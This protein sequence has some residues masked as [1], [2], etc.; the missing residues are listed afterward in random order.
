MSNVKP[1]GTLPPG[2]HGGPL[3]HVPG[4]AQPRLTIRDIAR[5]AGVSPSA[6]SLALNER[7]GIAETTRAR[8]LAIVERTG[9]VPNQRA[10]RL[11]ERRSGNI[12]VVHAA[13]SS[14]F[15]QLFIA[16]IL[17]AAL[18]ECEQ[19]GY[20]LVFAGVREEGGAPEV[21]R[22]RDVDGV[23]V[24]GEIP[25]EVIEA[26]AGVPMVLVDEHMRTAGV[27]AVEA[28]YA[29]GARAATAYLIRL[30]HRRIGYPVSYTH[31]TL[32]TN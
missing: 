30:G 32:P 3:A 6:V 10:R 11:L 25:A 14:P 23:L 2:G 18:A 21:V 24:I 28:D 29:Q 12:G 27:T 7:R 16:E 15:R 13:G 1:S 26:M 17:G 9:F 22:R 8:I 4:S 31:L 5:M 20:N 19:R